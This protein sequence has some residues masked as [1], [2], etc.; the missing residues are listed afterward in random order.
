MQIS[1]RKEIFPGVPNHHQGNTQNMHDVSLATHK[2]VWQH[3]AVRVKVQP[4]FS[5]ILVD[6]TTT[7]RL[8]PILE[9]LVE[10][11]SFMRIYVGNRARH[12]KLEIQANGK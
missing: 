6:K 10:S 4:S 3:V 1:K 2:K 11:I 8:R 12:F 7:P 5:K 9:Y